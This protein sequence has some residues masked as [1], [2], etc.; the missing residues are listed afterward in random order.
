[1]CGIAGFWGVAAPAGELVPILE[2]MARALDHRGPDSSGTWCLPEQ[3]LGF[4]HTRLAIVDL[5]PAGHQ[6]MHSADGR[7]TVTYNGEIYNFPQLRQELDQAGHTP[8]GGW[9][10]HCD[11]EVLLAAVQAWGLEAAL[12]RF[13]GMFAFALWDDR[14]RQLSLVRDRLGIKP[15]YLGFCGEHL[16]FGSELKALM[17]HP[18]WRG[19]L[20]H[21]ALERYLG[22]SC[23]PA[24]LSM[25]K[26]IYKLMPGSYL[27][28]DARQLRGRSLPRAVRWW[29]VPRVV[30]QGLQNPLPNDVEELADRLEAQLT[31]AVRLRLVADVPLGAFLSG[32][33]DSSTITALM[34]EQVSQPVRTFSIGSHATDYDEAAQAR[35]V[36]A[37][38]GTRHTELIVTPAEAQ[39]AI[40]RMPALFD[41]PF[42]D[43]S[44]VPTYLVARL[45]RQEVTVCLSGDGGD[46]LF[47]G[48]NRHFHAPPLWRRL[49][50]L[51]LPL[52]RGLAP[53][54]R[55]PGEA[56]LTGL[57]KALQALGRGSGSRP[58]PLLREKLQK[59]VEALPAPDRAAFYASLCATWQQPRALLQQPSEAPDP[60]L[61]LL[62]PE[63]PLPAGL[64]F[65]P[66]MMAKDQTGYLPDDI[67]TKLDRATMAVALEGRVPL[68]DHRVV[69]LAW[70]MPPSAHLEGRAG[71][72]ILRRVLWR[73]VPRELVERPKQGF[74]LPL[75][76]WLRGPLRDWAEA[77]LRPEALA[78]GG[79]RPEPVRRAWQQH[80]SGARA[81]HWQLW[82]VL[83]HQAWRE[84]F[85]I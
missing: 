77:L 4:A 1:M 14:T 80:L 70:R 26:G 27:T 81:Q 43:L 68:L 37:H 63:E 60:T 25:F 82:T 33:I 55:G 24:P 34:Q 32:G 6:P 52:R 74:D 75:D 53:L 71:K 22:L 20:N 64:D 47:A 57:F 69:E 42:A 46:E 19:E 40:V 49:S 56:A 73:R 3:G 17:R 66:W 65:M 39:D 78:A 15:L 51:P 10:G 54:L 85:R 72:R 13:V 23:V 83:M 58:L 76:A 28:L 84:H 36:A 50:A 62:A 16:L 45:A 59:L 21:A 8:A 31:E 30:A 5:S 18:A 48:Y 35:A 7:L 79:L 9:R 67:L 29:S 12:G 61:A 38:L 11:T 2:R 44:Q 41:E